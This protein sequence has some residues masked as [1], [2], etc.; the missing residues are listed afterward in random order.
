MPT[1]S[2]KQVLVGTDDCLNFDTST[3]SVK[4]ESISDT[5]RAMSEQGE[6]SGRSSTKTFV[7]GVLLDRSKSDGQ[8]RD[9][10]KNRRE[11]FVQ[12]TARRNWKDK[13]FSIQQRSSQQSH[14]DHGN[15]VIE[16][17]GK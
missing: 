13:C 12:N 7:E 4:G 6:R 14:G 1:Y 15:S 10:R 2:T 8:D 5:E 16:N 3:P 9:L 17:E 11:V